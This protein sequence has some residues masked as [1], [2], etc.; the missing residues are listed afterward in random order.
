MEN[1][2]ETKGVECV[3]LGEF[4]SKE[5]ED[6]IQESLM[7]REN[8]G[9][10]KPKNRIYSSV[11]INCNY[12]FFKNNDPTTKHILFNSKTHIYIEPALEVMTESSL[13][14]LVKHHDIQTNHSLL[15]LN[16]EFRIES[17]PKLEDMVKAL[18][19]YEFSELN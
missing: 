7:F 16:Q 8:L 17:E 13:L 10:S 3:L 19:K 12:R 9:I 2:F 15:H 11:I 18:F 4:D 5:F 6:Y 1:N 14:A